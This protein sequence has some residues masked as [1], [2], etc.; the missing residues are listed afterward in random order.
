M[1]RGR[2]L[3]VEDDTTIL[4]LLHDVAVMDGFDVVGVSWP[5]LVLDVTRQVQP[6]VILIDV[7]LPRRS[8]IE[9]AEELRAHGFE[10]TPMVA[11][12]ASRV[13]QALAQHS[14]V[15]QACIG[16]PFDLDALIGTIERAMREGAGVP[17]QGGTVRLEPAGPVKP[18]QE[19]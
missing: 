11:M 16:K 1:I 6:D 15:F 19:V 13:M 3:V 14:G 2:L 9:V 10:E 12:S 18:A 7:M 8:G 4:Q 17:G 5:D